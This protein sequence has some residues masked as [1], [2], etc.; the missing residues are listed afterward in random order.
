LRAI[1]VP[2]THKPEMRRK[3]RM[4][5]V[6]GMNYRNGIVVASDSL[7]TDGFNKRFVDKICTYV[8]CDDWGTVVSCAGGGDVI[9][10]FEQ[11]LR[12]TLGND[13]YDLRR[14]EQCVQSAIDEICQSH[15]DELEIVFGVF[16]G[17]AMF[18]SHLYRTYPKSHMSYTRR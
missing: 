16:G 3:P 14:I 12:D 6:L 2:G 11:R 5:F 9:R 15:P 18:E 1:R 10:K 17:P 7:E 4:T 13:S 8:V